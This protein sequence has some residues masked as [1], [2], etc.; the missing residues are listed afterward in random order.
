MKQKRRKGNILGYA[1]ISPWMIGFF[2]M[3][4]IPMCIS[5]Y[6]SF[7]DYNLL[8]E[9]EFIGF[10]NYIRMFTKDPDFW[11]ALKVTF[12]YVLI[13][14]PCRLAFALIVALLLNTKRKGG[15]IYRTLYYIPSI[16]GGSIAVSIVWRQM[17]G[18]KGVIMSLLALIGIDQKLSFIGNPK[19]ALGTLILLGVWQFGSSMLIFLAALK[20]IPASI[21]ESASLD[22]ASGLRKFFKITLPMISPTIFFNLILQIVN[23]FRA[24]T[25]SYII[26]DGGP[27]DST[28][29]YVLNLYRQAF[30]YFDMGYSSAMAWVLVLIIA[31]FA[32]IVFKTQNSWVYYESKG[33]K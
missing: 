4:F 14:I 20:Q 1:L 22:G 2:L 29:F 3:F 24:F 12:I 33:G 27:M 23:G 13:L 18:N 19:T 11:Q 5:L 16:I 6:Y 30:N 8:S 31:F 28:L 26:T 32:G 7:T 15:G 9:P 25:E 10:D 17:F 21:Y